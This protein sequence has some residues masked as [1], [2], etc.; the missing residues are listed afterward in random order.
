MRVAARLKRSRNTCV[1]TFCGADKQVSAFYHPLT[2]KCL[3]A[4]RVDIKKKNQEKEVTITYERAFSW[5]EPD[6]D[7][8]VATSKFLVENRRCH[9]W[10]TNKIPKGHVQVKVDDILDLLPT[11]KPKDALC[12][13]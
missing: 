13:V 2:V 9:P 4:L 7:E 11:V 5:D 12:L 8:V 3:P 10:Y 6:P 1:W